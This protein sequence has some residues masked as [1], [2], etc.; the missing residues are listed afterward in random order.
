MACCCVSCVYVYVTMFMCVSICYYMVYCISYVHYYGIYLKDR[1][2]MQTLLP[3]LHQFL[4]P[5]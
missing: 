1:V 5:F 2:F 4:F 3:F